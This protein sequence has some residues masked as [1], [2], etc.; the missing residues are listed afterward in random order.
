MWRWALGILAWLSLALWLGFVTLWAQS[1]LD[2]SSARTFRD[3]SL[4]C[5]RGKLTFTEGL[6]ALDATSGT[7]DTRWA[8]PGI[9]YSASWETHYHLIVPRIPQVL[10]YR[11]VDVH[12]WLPV[13]I[14]AILPSLWLVGFRRRR[15]Q[16][17]RR[18]LGL[19]LTCGYDLRA[20][21]D[22]CPECGTPAAPRPATTDL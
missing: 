9:S 7:K 8:L 3:G 5:A 1:Y 15:R 22:R 14:T 4:R 20:T 16:R 13:T 21:P 18:R 17:R 12:C 2:P 19:C 11:Q 6:F 10:L